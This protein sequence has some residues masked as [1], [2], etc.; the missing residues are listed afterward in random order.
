MEKKLLIL[1]LGLA[2]V[3]LLAACS[4]TEE[5]DEDN[6]EPVNS[7]NDENGEKDEN[8]EDDYSDE[9]DDGDDKESLTELPSPGELDYTQEG[10]ITPEDAQ[11]VIEDRSNK[12]MEAIRDLDQDKLATLTHPEAGVRFTQYSNVNEDEDLVFMP[13]EMETFFDDPEEYVWGRYDGVGDDIKLTPS[14]YYDEFI[15]SQDFIDPEEIGYNEIISDSGLVEENQFDVYE[16]AII[17]EYYFSGFE[18]EYDGM[19][20]ESLRLVFQYYEDTWLLVGVIH[21]QWTT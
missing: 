10:I 19:D 16:D 6:G 3:F 2:L 14:E 15:Y 11:M 8:D 18:E 4:P 21:N 7:V 1:L 12:T 20:W 17:V 5:N 13:E 9:N